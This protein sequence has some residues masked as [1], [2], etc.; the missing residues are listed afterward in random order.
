MQ[1]LPWGEWSIAYTRR[2]QGIPLLFLH[3]GGT[4]HAIWLDVID[5]LAPN[6]DCIAIDLLGYGAS[7]KPGTS[8]TMT[9]YVALVEHVLDTLQVPSVYLVGNCMGS[10]ISVHVARKMPERIRG[11]VLVNPLTEAT[12]KGGWLASV[13]ALRQK[14][15]SVASPLF[16]AI[17][18]IRLPGWTAPMTLAFQVGGAGKKQAVHTQDALR[19]CHSSEGQLRSMLAVLDDIDA[20]AEVDRFEPT[21]GFPPILTIWGRQNRVLSSAAGQALN[22]RLQ[23]VN[24][25]ELDDCGHLLMMERPDQVAEAI[26]HF[27]RQTEAVGRGE[28]RP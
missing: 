11:L 13:L 14:A 28:Q 8:Y 18:A 19:A 4:S 15:P 17:S 21:T 7:S 5:A 22:A 10:A 16:R 25:I 2:G 3:N 23:P 9:D 1:A 20:Y 27:V 6:F 24:A 26:A 12:F